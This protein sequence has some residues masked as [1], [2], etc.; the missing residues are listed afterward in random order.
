MREAQ[1]KESPQAMGGSSNC[2]SDVEA[3]YQYWFPLMG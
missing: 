1:G 2:A 3:E